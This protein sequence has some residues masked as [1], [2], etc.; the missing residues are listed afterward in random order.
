MQSVENQRP[1]PVE[2]VASTFM[3]EE[4]FK[5]ETCRKQ[6]EIYRHVPLKHQLTFSVIAHTIETFITAFAGN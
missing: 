6:A 5:Q 4:K 1:F 2:H 3:V